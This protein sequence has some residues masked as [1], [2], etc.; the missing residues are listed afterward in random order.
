MVAAV[1]CQ[2]LE[3]RYGPHEALRGLDLE[4]PPGALF[5]FLGPNGAGKSTTLR[6]LAGLVRAD[7]GRAELHG[8]DVRRHVAAAAGTTFLIENAVFLPHLTARETLKR[9]ASFMRVPADEAQLDR[10][11]LAHARD[12]K[13]GGFSHGMRQRLG[14]ACAL[15]GKPDLMVLDEPQNGLDPQ[16][17]RT[18]R[19]LL[20]EENARG[21]TVLVS[22]HR[23]AE[24]EG[25]CTHAAL[26]VSGRAVRAGPIDRLLGEGE[27]RH[28]ITV[29]NARRAQEAIGL[30]CEATDGAL[31][32]RADRERAA[33]AAAAC[34]RAGVK[35]FSLEPVLRT[36]DE[37]YLDE[38]GGAGGP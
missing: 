21:A 37:L 11:G 4:V 24:V 38:V 27:P 26:I 6:I 7:N 33:A 15:L 10:V 1:L 18:I 14:L 13:T 3:K 31:V 23:L 17:L 5:G 8:T 2:G 12:R 34:V 22:V 20:K 28:R 9:A 36:L 30:P 25:L 29:S 16:G 32:F 19:A 35:V